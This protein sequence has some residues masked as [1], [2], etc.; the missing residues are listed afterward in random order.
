MNDDVWV[1]N[2]NVQVDQFCNLLAEWSIATKHVWLGRLVS[3]GDVVP[4]KLAAEIATPLGPSGLEN[5][6]ESL[7]ICSGK[8]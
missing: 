5:I 2:E 4:H 8:L 3:R 1:L 6:F 7:K